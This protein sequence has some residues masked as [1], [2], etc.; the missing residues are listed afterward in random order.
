MR[1]DGVRGDEGDLPDALIEKV[2]QLARHLDAMRAAHQQTSAE[3]GLSRAH[4][5]TALADSLIARARIEDEARDLA[6]AGYQ[7]SA[8]RR[9]LSRSVR[10]DRR[11]DGRLARFRSIGRALVIERSGLWEDA[12]AGRLGRLRAIA[13][14][15]RRGGDPAVQPNA[16]FDQAWY[17][18]QRPDIAGSGTSPLVHYLLRGAGEGVDPHPLFRSSYYA[19]RAGGELGGLTPLEH[20]VRFGAAEG[21][22]PHPLFDIRYYVRQARDL[23][24]SGENPLAHYMREG[25]ARGLS[26]HPLFDAPF[27]RAQVEKAGLTG[28]AS[29]A[30]YLTEGSAKGLKPHP[31]FDPAWYRERHPDIA[32]SG[33]E[34][35]VHYVLGGGGEGRLPSPWFDAPRYMALRGDGLAGRNPLLDYLEGG[36]WA[37]AEPWPGKA[38]LGFLSAVTEFAQSGVTPLEHWARQGAD[39]I[40]SA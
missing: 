18:A 39:Q 35:L 31:L 8:S 25:A 7:A 13:A 17:L 16:L 3:N 9:A 38:E 27:Y 34:P 15:A 40:P 29:L 19:E 20:F 24:A 5:G 32:E 21:R 37:I 28:E 11:L 30:H 36:A 12:A 26:P 14:Y 33:L 2:E 10:L 23:I 22:A 6:F 1:T 4:L